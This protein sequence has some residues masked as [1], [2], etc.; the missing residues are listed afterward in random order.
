MVGKKGVAKERLDPS[1]YI[2]VHGELWKAEVMDGGPP[3]EKGETVEVHGI[4]G[5]VLLVKR[6]S[7]KD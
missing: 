5:R 1:G 2:L 6:E 7:K 3:V 4:R